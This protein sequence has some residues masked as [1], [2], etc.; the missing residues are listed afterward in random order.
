MTTGKAIVLLP[1]EPLSSGDRL[2]PEHLK[3]HIAFPLRVEADADSR[4]FRSTW[5]DVRASITLAA[6]SSDV[7]TRNHL[8]GTQ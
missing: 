8:T 7:L 4:I 3:D 1:M 5:D 2:T 6:S